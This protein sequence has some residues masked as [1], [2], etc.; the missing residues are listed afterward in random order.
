VNDSENLKKAK[1]EP[2]ISW[3]EV[4]HL[5]G[6]TV[7]RGYN[8][9]F[10]MCVSDQSQAWKGLVKYKYD[11]FTAREKGYG[12]NFYR[13]AGNM[14]LRSYV[15]ITSPYRL[16][17]TSPSNETFLTDFRHLLVVENDLNKPAFGAFFEHDEADLLTQY[18][19][20]K[21]HIVDLD[22][23]M[24]GNSILPKFDQ[25]SQTFVF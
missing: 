7:E 21:W 20:K 4:S 11:K 24:K 6:V 15:V 3:L 22:G 23:V 9:F 13:L 2:G 5:K 19:P 16:K 25:L 14:V 8:P 1:L 12:A 10:E 18:S 17:F